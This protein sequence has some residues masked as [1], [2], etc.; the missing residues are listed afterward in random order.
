MTRHDPL[1]SIRILLPAK[2]FDQAKSRLNLSDRDR[3]L[4]ARR[5]FVSTLDVSLQTVSPRQVFVMT[6]DPHARVLARRR[7]VRTVADTRG[8]LNPSLESALATL[9]AR[10]PDDTVVVV[11][12]DLPRLTA[13]VLRAALLEAA[14]SR[15]P[16]H[17]VDHHGLGTTFVSIPPHWNLPMVFGSESA[18]RFADAGSAPVLF[19]PP[20]ITHDL[21]VLSDLTALAPQLK[22]KLCPSTSSP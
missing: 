17:V 1:G 2:A 7:Q 16:R 13:P 9:T 11:V 19:P 18:Q 4:I 3:S 6:D 12:A 14:A 15:Q 10:F 20:A 22:E 5:L 8:G 21:D